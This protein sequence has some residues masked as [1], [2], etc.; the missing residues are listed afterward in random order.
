MPKFERLQLEGE[1]LEVGSI[2]TARSSDQVIWPPTRGLYVTI[3]CTWWHDPERGP[4]M[5]TSQS[6]HWGPIPWG[7][8]EAH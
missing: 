1:P 3:C 5:E 6:S 2:W 4:Q 7:R 8:S